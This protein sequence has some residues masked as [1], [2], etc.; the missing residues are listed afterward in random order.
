[1]ESRID[2]LARKINLLE[3]ELRKEREL[4]RD[5]LR[6]LAVIRSILTLSSDAYKTSK[7][8]S[9][10]SKS[11]RAGPLARDITEILMTEGPLNISQLTNLLREIGGR[12]SRKTVAKKLREL[13]ELGVVDT[14]EGKKSEKL[15]KV[16]SE[17]SGK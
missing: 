8:I 3:E 15:F 6:E 16:R 13:M 1:M 17:D 14:I 9:L 4:N 5:V 12:A 10:L 7:K 2:E 11:L